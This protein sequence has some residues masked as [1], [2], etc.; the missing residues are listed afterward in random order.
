MPELRQLKDEINTWKKMLER[1]TG[2]DAYIIKK[3]LIDMHRD[4]YIIK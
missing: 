4:Q 1:A 2:K 3:A